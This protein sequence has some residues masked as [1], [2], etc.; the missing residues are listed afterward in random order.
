MTRVSTATN[1]CSSRSHASRTTLVHSRERN[2]A[3]SNEPFESPSI[4]S[5]PGEPRLPDLHPNRVGPIHPVS[6]LDAVGVIERHHV[7]HRP[8]H[9]ER[10]WRVD[11]G[12]YPHREVL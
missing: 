9:P 8:D 10:A 1:S 5:S 7:R 6:R 11:V 12:L 2:S 4:S 3:L